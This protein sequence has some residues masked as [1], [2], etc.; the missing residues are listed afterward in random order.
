MK[1]AIKL[2]IFACCALAAFLYVFIFLYTTGHR[3]IKYPTIGT[4]QEKP[5][6]VM[7]FI[8]SHAKP[9]PPDP[10]FKESELGDCTNNGDATMKNLSSTCGCPPG[11]N[12][13]SHLHRCCQIHMLKMMKD[14]YEEMISAD[15]PFVLT[16]GAVQG[17]V[18]NKKLKLND[19]DVN[20]GLPYEYWYSDV[21]VGILKRLASRGYC[22]WFRSPTWTKIWSSIIPVDIRPWSVVGGKELVFAGNDRGNPYNI[23]TILPP[24]LA[25]LEDMNVLLPNRP[26]EYLDRLFRLSDFVPNPKEV[27]P[28]SPYFEEREMG[29]CVRNGDAKSKNLSTKCGC[30]TVSKKS[31]NLNACCRRH[32]VNLLRRVY[33]EIMAAD[34]PMILTG[35]AVIG[36]Y[37][38][39]T[40]VPYDDDIDAGLE[41]KHWNSPQ[42]LAVLDRL[43]TQGLCVWLRTPTWTKIWSNVMAF[44]LFAFNIVGGS[45]VYF[46]GPS[47]RNPYNLSDILPGRVEVVEGVE[48]LIPGHP[49]NYLDN[50]YGRDKWRKPWH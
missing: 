15:V 20:A 27:F 6:A 50:L 37:R 45:K 49:V 35:G 40:L 11:S 14:V 24:R 4:P 8:A 36:W 48:V 43:A 33:A 47:E 30:P 13:S 34:I 2:P 23:T 32:L 38:N 3:L 44:D 46:D 1:L 16:G 18:S 39:R 17:W 21:Y 28:P 9:F 31:H 22:V 29:D 41:Y 7:N 19:F 42:Y 5:K 12:P 26:K 25:V 10:N